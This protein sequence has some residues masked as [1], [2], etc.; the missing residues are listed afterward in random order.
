M[1]SAEVVLLGDSWGAFIGDSVRT[2]LN[3]RGLKSVRI[4]NAAVPAST[5]DEWQR[6]VHGTLP[7]LLASDTNA[8][9]IQLFLGGNDILRKL[10]SSLAA[11]AAVEPTATNVVRVLAA[12]AAASPAPILYSS[13]D[14]LPGP[15]RTGGTALEINRWMTELLTRVAQLVAADA[16]LNAR[17][18]VLN[19]LGTMQIHYGIP[20]LGLLPSDPA[21]PNVELPGPST[22]FA[23]DIHLT[24]V[25]YDLFFRKLYREFH[26]V[27]IER[28]ILEA[29]AAGQFRVRSAAGL[30][31]TVFRSADLAVWSPACVL[32]NATG[33]D[34]FEDPA[35]ADSFGTLYFRLR[36]DPF[37]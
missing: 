30:R 32:T 1:M 19:A 9:S 17:V 12:I 34:R 13:Y 7:K 33:A 14:Y 31:L 23:D 6:G 8:V 18:T 16:D 21:L 3:A 35:R 15:A 11:A 25:G 5:A 22:A 27:L 29:T 28:S 4:H 24:R 36:T 26:A 2:Q 37:D 10:P 20:K